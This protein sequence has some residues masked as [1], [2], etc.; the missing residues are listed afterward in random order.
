MILWPVR[1]KRQSY[2]EIEQSEDEIYKIIKSFS[3][4]GARSVRAGYL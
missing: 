3:D 1:H 2:S 4:R